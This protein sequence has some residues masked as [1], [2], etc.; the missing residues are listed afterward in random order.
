M[1]NLTHLVVLILLVSFNADV[2]ADKKGKG[3][4][5]KSKGKHGTIFGEEWYIQPSANGDPSGRNV[6]I[7]KGSPQAGNTYGNNLVCENDL[8]VARIAYTNTSSETIG[9][10]AG[11]DTV[12]PD[13]ILKFIFITAPCG[14]SQAN[15]IGEYVW[16][17]PDDPQS[18]NPRGA[19]ESAVG[20][21]LNEGWG[22]D[23]ASL[24]ANNT[25]SDYK[26]TY[27]PNG[28]ATTELR[29]SVE[30][31][32]D[33]DKV[34]QANN[35][36][37]MIS[38]FPGALEIGLGTYSDVAVS[39]AG[40]YGSSGWIQFHAKG[41]GV[42]QQMRNLDS[43]NDLVYPAAGSDRQTR[44]EAIYYRIDGVETGSTSGTVFES[45]SGTAAGLFFIE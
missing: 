30:A 45:G 27:A 24:S 5:H 23:I 19:W 28:L 31:Y 44:L 1:K 26:L 40:E 7:L 13:E 37:E 2:L 10:A 43:A 4:H 38:H 29:H 21:E 32:M 25:S 41:V 11:P 3:K 36:S 9:S 39:T 6:I 17:L 8:Y 42:I 12:T 35:F 20:T 33:G 34:L 18:T 22:P 16:G 14:S 15:Y